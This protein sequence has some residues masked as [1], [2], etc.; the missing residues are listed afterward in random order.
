MEPVFARG[1]AALFGTSNSIGS[2]ETSETWPTKAAYSTCLF[3]WCVCIVYVYMYIYT[4][5][6]MHGWMHVCLCLYA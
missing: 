5:V 1:F 2:D 6:C 4:Y 3:V